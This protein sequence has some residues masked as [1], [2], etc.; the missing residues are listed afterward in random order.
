MSEISRIY[1]RVVE[2][3]Q[4]LVLDVD[5]NICEQFNS[6]INKHI[7]G[8]RIHFALKNAYNARVEA[9][10]VS[11]NTSGQYIRLI[12]KKI[13]KKSPGIYIFHYLNI[14]IFIYCLY[15]FYLHRNSW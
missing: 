8:K 2:N 13:T 6:I 9:A 3:A 1:H 5:N 12:H 7:A 4:S 15:F 10:V 11:F 14:Y